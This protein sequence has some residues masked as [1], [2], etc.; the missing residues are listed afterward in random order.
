M[1]CP[2]SLAISNPRSLVGNA[3][4]FPAFLLAAAAAGQLAFRGRDRELLPS[5]DLIVKSLASTTRVGEMFL[6]SCRRYLSATERLSNP[7]FES[8]SIVPLLQL[9][10]V[11][12]TVSDRKTK[13]RA[14][15]SKERMAALSRTGRQIYFPRVC[16]SSCLRDCGTC[17]RLR[18]RRLFIFDI[19]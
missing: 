13:G 9:C 2:G 7:F 16:T 4:A 10:T 14:Q 1:R 17:T 8:A 3:P 12:E 18:V 11:N 6:N 19:Y 15:R 5:R